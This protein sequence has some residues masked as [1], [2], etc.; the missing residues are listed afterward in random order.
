MQSNLESTTLHKDIAP[1]FDRP[2]TKDTYD[3]WA[4]SVATGAV[5]NAFSDVAFGTIEWL[6]VLGRPTTPTLSEGFSVKFWLYQDVG[7]D[8]PDGYMPRWTHTPIP[9][10]TFDGQS[11]DTTYR[12]NYIVTNMAQDRIY[13]ADVNFANGR[14]GWPLLPS[15]FLTITPEP[16]FFEK[17]ADFLLTKYVVDSGFA[18]AQISGW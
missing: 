1:L 3:V 12:V 17:T 18:R 13:L 6:R 7:F 10:T 8:T 9:V 15:R 4:R 5:H 11:D 2:L 16:F 14:K